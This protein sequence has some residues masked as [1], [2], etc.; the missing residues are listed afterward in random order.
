MIEFTGQYQKK[1]QR[2]QLQRDTS[3]FALPLQEGH[4]RVAMT[5]LREP[6]LSN[7]EP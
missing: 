7:K 4:F 3:P 2:K 1:N 6:D 5:C